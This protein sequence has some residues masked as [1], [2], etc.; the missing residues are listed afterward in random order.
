ML[1]RSGD[2]EYLAMRYVYEGLRRD[3]AVARGMWVWTASQASRPSKDSNKRLDLHHV[4][5]SMHK[6]RVA[7]Q[8]ITLNPKDDGQ[9]MEFFIAKNRMGKARFSVGPIVTDF[10]KARIVPRAREFQQW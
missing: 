8:I 5:D 1:F 6:V 10:E 2:N 3:I 7:D 9:Q 4:A